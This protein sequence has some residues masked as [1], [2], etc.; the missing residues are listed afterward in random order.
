VRQEN[1]VGS[2]DILDVLNAEQALL[3]SQVALVQAEREKYVAAY[4]LFQTMGDSEIVLA[5]VPVGRFDPDL[6]TVR[7]RNS[8]DEFGA[9][10]DPRN[11]RSRNTIPLGP[12]VAGPPR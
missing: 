1:Q 2:R 7:V 5:G 9:D 6:N 12:P 11:D 3:N 8:W 10:P 4:R